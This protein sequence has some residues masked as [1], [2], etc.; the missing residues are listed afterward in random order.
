MVDSGTLRDLAQAVLEDSKG[1]DIQIIDLRDRSSFADF[2]VIASGNSTRQVKAMADRLVERAKAAGVK[3]LGVE[4]D[5][6]AEWVLV[7]LADVVV[8][9]MLPQTRAFY[10]LEKLW[11]TP[12]ATRSAQA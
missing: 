10:N 4:G 5:R 2:M 7:D 1:E 6:E 8:H 3:P 11:S 9:L 12:P